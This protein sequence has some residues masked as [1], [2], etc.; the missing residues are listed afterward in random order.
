MYSALECPVHCSEQHWEEVEAAFFCFISAPFHDK[1]L[2][3]NANI[4]RHKIS[5]QCDYAD[6]KYDTEL[7]FE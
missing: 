5:K 3:T 7:T 4:K 1:Y 6:V 2:H